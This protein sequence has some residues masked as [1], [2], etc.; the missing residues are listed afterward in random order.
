[1]EDGADKVKDATCRN[2]WQGSCGFF[3]LFLRES[4][5]GEKQ[6]FS[7]GTILRSK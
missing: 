7:E 3:F 2:R 4:L 6:N 1:M 5:C